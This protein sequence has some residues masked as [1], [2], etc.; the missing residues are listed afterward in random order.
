[1]LHR[2]NGLLRRRELTF[3][4]CVVAVAVLHTLTALSMPVAAR[5]LSPMEVAATLA[6][7]LAHAATY[8]LGDTLRARFGV[9]IYAAAQAAL[10]LA[11]ALVAKPSALTLGL[12]MLLTVEMLMVAGDRWG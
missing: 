2:T 7:L 11:F 12:L 6:I 8:W 10:L 4:G 1:M 3:A 9:A 5:R